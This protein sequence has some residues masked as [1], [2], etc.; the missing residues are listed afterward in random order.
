[1]SSREL[2]TR[3]NTEIATIA[4]RY[5]SRREYSRLELYSRLLAK[6]FTIKDINT[7]LDN[8]G[9]KGYQS[10]ERFAEMFLASRANRG[11]GPF[12]IRMELSQK[13]VA[14]TVIKQLFDNSGIDW[15]EQARQARHKHFGAQSPTDIKSLS[16]QVRYLRCKG[17]YQQHIDFALSVSAVI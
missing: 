16:K 9:A 7:T 10:D 17:F 6:K 4:V 1:M 5:L 3:Q 12:K 8:L 13:G 11:N 15:F 14:E 2:E